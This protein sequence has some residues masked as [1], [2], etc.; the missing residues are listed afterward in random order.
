MQGGF[1]FARVQQRI[2]IPHIFSERLID[3]REQSGPQ[4]RYR[5]GAANHRLLPVNEDVVAGFG[6]G[7]SGYVGHAAA[8]E[9]IRRFRDAGALLIAGQREK[10]AD[11]TAGGAFAAG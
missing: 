4:R 2:H 1:H 11:A 8:Y 6:I 3:A 5:A 9:S 10:F 7:V